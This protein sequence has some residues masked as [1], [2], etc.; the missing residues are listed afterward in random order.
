MPF[1]DSKLTVAVPQEKR[2]VLKAELGKAV[3]LLGKPES[4]LMV[5][6]HPFIFPKGKISI[7]CAINK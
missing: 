2:D 5:G 6:F 3:A 4:F 1:I 7:I